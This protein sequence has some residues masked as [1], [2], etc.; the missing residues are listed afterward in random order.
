MVSNY[1]SELI[2]AGFAYKRAGNCDCNNYYIGQIDGFDIKIAKEKKEVDG[3]C[4]NKAD[5]RCPV[6][7]EVWKEGRYQAFKYE[8]LKQTPSWESV[9]IWM[10]EL[11]AAL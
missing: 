10:K 4:R 1:H 11:K 3:W 8:N 2:K 9:L 6:R 7:W 5:N